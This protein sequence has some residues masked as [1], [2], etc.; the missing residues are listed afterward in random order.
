MSSEILTLALKYLSE[1]I[2]NN[3]VSITCLEIIVIND[4]T[5][6]KI[7]FKSVE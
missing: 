5:E 7:K 3:K 6:V 2:T 4:I 1:S